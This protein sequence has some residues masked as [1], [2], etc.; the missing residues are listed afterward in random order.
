MFDVKFLQPFGVELML[1]EGWSP[2]SLPSKHY[3]IDLLNKH[4]IILL[5]D[6][7]YT[8][9]E[10]LIEFAKHIGPLLEWD[11][12]SVMEMRVDENPKNYLFTNGPVP[13]HW[14]GAFYRVPKYLLFQ[15]VAAPL[16][17]CGGETIFSNTTHIWQ[18]NDLLIADNYVLIHGR[19][20]FKQFSPRHL[21]RIQIL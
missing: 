10:S 17:S 15:C 2:L 1:Q 18:N 19:H 8:N 14:D 13:F 4:K 5:R 11:F 16:A 20:A 21:R 9:S 7:P 12:G 6:S 3:F